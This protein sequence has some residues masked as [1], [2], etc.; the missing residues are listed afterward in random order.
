MGTVETEDGK[1]TVAA[2]T[3][4]TYLAGIIPEQIAHGIGSMTTDW[5]PSLPEFKKLCLGSSAHP[6]LDEVANI[7]TVAGGKRGSIA[8]RFKHP[9]AFFISQQEGYDG[10][11]AKTAR[12]SEI[13][14]HI[15]PFYDKAVQTGYP[16]FIAAHF[17][18]FTALP[19]IETNEAKK[20]RFRAGFAAI[21]RLKNDIGL[22][23]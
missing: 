23:D 1:L 21:S 10:L 9:I 16:G 22:V 3:W 18:D 19:L 7:L 11:L 2:K 15:R 6:A 13:K 4:Q 14:A 12:T 17:K 8:A 20:Q 5:P